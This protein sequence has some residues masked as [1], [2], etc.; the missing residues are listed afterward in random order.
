MS[1]YII[2]REMQD[3]DTPAVSQ[4]FRNAYTSNVHN[5][6]KNALCHEV[7]LLKM[8]ISCF[9]NLFYILGDVSVNYHDFSLTFHLFWNTFNLLYFISTFSITWYVFDNI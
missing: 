1:F 5:T 2:I 9:D 3:T 4:V 7:L 6:W 8:Y